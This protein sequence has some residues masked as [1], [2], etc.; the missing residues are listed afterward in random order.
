MARQDIFSDTAFLEFLELEKKAP[1]LQPKGLNLIGV[2][3]DTRA[4]V[5]FQYWIEKG[6]MFLSTGD[7]SSFLAK[8]GGFFSFGK[9]KEPSQTA[10]C[11]NTLIQIKKAG[12][13][14][15]Y[16]F[17]KAW[18]MDFPVA[19]GSI[20]WCE[21]SGTLYCAEDS[22]TIHSILPDVNNLMKYSA[23]T[24]LKVHTDK[25]NKIIFDEGKKVLYSIGD[26]RKFKET[27]LDK[28]KILNEFEVSSKRPNCMFISKEQRVAYVGDAEGNVK[29]ID[30]NRNPPTCVNNIKANS[31][32]SI[33]SIDVRSNLICCGCAETGK[34]PVYH[35]DDPKSSSSQPVLKYTLNGYPGISCVRYWKEKGLVYVG[36]NNGV[37]AVFCKYIT[38]QNPFCKLL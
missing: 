1:E 7:Q 30:L 10:G 32:D 9:K 28:K 36:H 35:L 24:Y 19:A 21:E 25:I 3:V 27:N 37:L 29:I 15:D 8:S 34:I 14:G 23:P 17:D 38:I 12:E 31:K 20:D 33:V 6:V 5:D 16:H 18:F 11:L 22:G 26:D 13:I 4:C 2:H